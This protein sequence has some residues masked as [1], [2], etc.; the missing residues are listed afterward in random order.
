VP[1]ISSTPPNSTTAT[2]TGL[3]KGLRPLSLKSVSPI[4]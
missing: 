2:I 1:V 3:A 4:Q